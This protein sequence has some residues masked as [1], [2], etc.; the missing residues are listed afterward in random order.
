MES[1][2]SS[3]N[4]RAM[5]AISIVVGMALTACSATGIRGLSEVE[6]KYFTNLKTHLEGSATRLDKVLNAG[7]AASEEA[8]LREISI[9][10]E[11]IRRAKLVY[12]VREVLTAP[13]SD[14]AAFIQITRNK[15]ILYHLAEAALGENEKLAAELAKGQEERRQLV[16]GLRNLNKL[17]SQSIDSN[18]ILHNYLNRSGTAQLSDILGEVGRQ[19]AAFNEEI[20]TAD[21]NNPVIQRLVET[22]K[23][24][25][26]R[27]Q[28]ADDGLTK[29][30]DIWSKLNQDKK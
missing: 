20:K 19:L 7:T 11:N 4:T 5:F 21:Q 6:T 25:D 13:K 2:V 1:R 24:A 17:V 26:K 30:I 29:F 8:A 18:E 15:V 28:Q 12:S 14:S 22:G 3:A 10:H 23:A 16:V 9:L 27:V